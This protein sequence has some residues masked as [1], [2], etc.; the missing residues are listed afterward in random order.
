M[1]TT[2]HLVGKT[3]LEVRSDDEADLTLVLDDGTHVRLQA[4]GWEAD[5]IGVQVLDLA[6]QNALI[7]ARVGQQHRRWL[8]K[9]IAD[10]KWAALPD[11]EKE[12]QRR[13]TQ[14]MRNLMASVWAPELAAADEH[15]RWAAN[16][17]FVGKVAT[18]PVEPT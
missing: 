3:I 4:E 6:A 8:Q 16:R 7:R 14:A 1:D 9:L 18:I 13:E 12:R 17:Q 11:A 2:Q 5:G 10:A 15:F